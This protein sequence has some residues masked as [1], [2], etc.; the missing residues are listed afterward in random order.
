MRWTS[1]ARQVGPPES[2]CHHARMRTNEGRCLT[3]RANPN[4]NN[5]N[6]NNNYYYHYYH[7]SLRLPPYAHVC[8]HAACVLVV[9]SFANADFIDVASGAIVIA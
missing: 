3:P 9:L 7:Y 8:G 2:Y 1:S 5:H 6:N 4:N